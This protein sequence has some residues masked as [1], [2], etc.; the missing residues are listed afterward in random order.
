MGLRINTNISALNAHRYLTSNDGHLSRSL[1][2]LSSGL[3]I[4]RSSDDAAG[5]AIS[6]KMRAQI[7][8]L[9][10]AS[11]NAQ[12]GVSFLQTAEGALQETT[13]ILQRMRELS[14]QAANDTLTT[15]DRTNIAAE[16]S[17][18]SAEVQRIATTT[19]FNTKRLI[20]GS[21]AGGLTLQIGANSN[22][23]LNVSIGTA[24]AAALTVQSGNLDVS[25][26][27]AASATIAG[28]DTAISQVTSIRANLGAY[29][30]RLEHTISNL[31]VQAENLAAAESR[32]RDLDMA[33]EVANLSK[34]QILQQS[35]TAMLA[36]ANSSPQSI[37]GLLR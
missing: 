12:D 13:V 8:G 2:R 3:R 7:G 25:S 17:Q 37:L 26:A 30:N 31:N 5:L 18:L 14:V 23:V 10:M 15:A 19:E 9:S 32:I 20:D 24:T 6:E 22:Q 35:S 4:N 36:Q 11:R 16:L 21:Q 1:E 33:K 29:I 28:I 34:I 27:S